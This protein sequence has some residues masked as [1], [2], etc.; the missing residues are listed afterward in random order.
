MT[1]TP[2]IP[3]GA[4][5]GE[6]QP[7]LQRT[8]GMLLA[9]QQKLIDLRHVRDRELRVLDGIVRFS[10]RTSTDGDP[11]AFW[12]SVADA[13]V[14]SFDCE[15]A[16]VV[17]LAGAAT[18][19]IGLRGPGPE[20]QEHAAELRRML[21][22]AMERGAGWL[23]EEA[24]R[25]F[26]LGSEPLATLMFAAVVVGGGPRRLVVAAVSK[27]KQPFFP[28]IDAGSVPLMR[29]FASQVAALH[30]MHESRQQV[31]SQLAWLDRAHTALRES[32]DKYRHV[33]ADAPEGLALIHCATGI[34]RDANAAL[35]R[36]CGA[37]VELLVG[38]L[39]PWPSGCGDEGG[40]VE[41]EM[42]MRDGGTLPVEVKTSRVEFGGERYRFCVVTDLRPRRQADAEQQRLREQVHQ[43][44]KMESIGRLAGG[45]AHDFNNL[46]T[47]ISGNGELLRGALFDP[48][49]AQMVEEILGASRRA[50]SLTQQLLTFSRKQVIRPQVTDFNQQFGD[51][52]RLYRRLIGE[53][54]ELAFAACDESTPVLADAAQLG[55]VFANLALNARDAIRATGRPGRIDVRT[56]VV[57]DPASLPPGEY[58]RL[59]VA[60]D[61][62]GMDAQTLQHV[63][64][65]FYTT[66]AVGE[67]TGLGLATVFGIVQQNRG[68]IA[69]ASDV[70]KGTTFT[71]HWPLRR[72]AVAAAPAPAG[73]SPGGGRE[74][75]LLVEDDR[76]VR[77]F[78]S[79]ALRGQGYEVRAAEGADEAIAWLDG[80]RRVPAILVTDVVMPKVNGK[81]L[82][83]MV[84]KRLPAIPVLFVSGYSEDILAQ[85]GVIGA[86]VALL[87]KPFT[88]AELSAR[89][90]TMIDGAGAA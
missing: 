76:G 10:E 1:S 32:E 27:A 19:M 34:V 71:I 35:A 55:Q 74:L 26:D 16:I 6:P 31:A 63:F 79:S 77:E 5:G 14:A 64:E 87:E 52:A 38:K 30:D 20:R 75:V 21:D 83:E 51:A 50:Q 25:G 47:V 89:I 61:G 40:V 12:E 42:T 3:G 84:R 43:L 41:V 70:G 28:P 59:V 69:C 66:K 57:R 9:T 81:A 39:P 8:V 29:L 53:D 86:D 15:T 33:F 72:D 60:D 62:A 68:G 78:A 46:L 85:Q 67:G 13:C 18:R 65:P 90:R 58:V 80:E 24:M 49:Q 56:T 23:G 88:V 11:A 2:E 45:V 4:G 37:P 82:A 36:L 54:V 48:E 7:E 22:G 17:E 44:R 73:A